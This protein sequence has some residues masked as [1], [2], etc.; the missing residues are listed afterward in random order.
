M[1]GVHLRGICG[2]QFSPQHTLK[3]IFFAIKASSFNEIIEYK[4]IKR[5]KYF[6]IRN[7]GY[8]YCV[9]DW[10]I[11][12][13]PGGKKFVGEHIV[14]TQWWNLRLSALEGGKKLN[15]VTKWI[16]TS[17]AMEDYSCGTMN[18]VDLQRDEFLSGLGLLSCSFSEL[19]DMSNIPVTRFVFSVIPLS[20]LIGS[21]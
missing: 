21:H 6:R 5:N 8:C 13:F 4:P 16:V 12:F 1:Y 14:S 17:V 15:I 18:A 19:I 9:I 20:S 2:T 3:T 10:A 11:I 7:S